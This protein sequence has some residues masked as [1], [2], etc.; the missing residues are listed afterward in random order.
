[1][2][3]LDDAF[4]AK[5][6]PQYPETD[7]G[8]YIRLIGVTDGEVRLRGTMSRVTFES[9]YKWKTRNRSRRFLDL[10]NYDTL[11]APAFRKS[12][13]AQPHDKLPELVQGNSSLPGVRVPVA[14]TL[15]HFIHPN[16]MPIM[17]VR[18]VAVLVAAGYV[19]SLQI[20]VPKYEL[21]RGAIERIRIDCPRR[22]LREIDRALFAYHKIYLDNKTAKCSSN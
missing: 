21:F 16:V 19:T 9:I 3:Q 2:D 13:E 17:D 1:M 14:S 20:D 18:T 4:V 10:H 22:S 11:Y 15:L 7:E 12:L 5:W 6:S 8:E